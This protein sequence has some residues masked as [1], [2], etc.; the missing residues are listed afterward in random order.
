MSERVSDWRRGEGAVGCLL[1]RQQQEEGEDLGGGEN[2]ERE[3]E[4]VCVEL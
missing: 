4:S 2:E 3:R 1:G